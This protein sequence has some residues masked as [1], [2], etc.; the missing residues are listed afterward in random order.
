[1]DSIESKLIGK[2]GEKFGNEP[3]LGDGLT[4]I[5]VDSVGMAEFTV[6]I[7][8]EFGITVSDEIFNVETVQELADY[9]R[10]RQR[11]TSS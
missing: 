11:T 3:E 7:E 6:E 10:E 1:M 4:F 9:I 5:G 8:N 2:L